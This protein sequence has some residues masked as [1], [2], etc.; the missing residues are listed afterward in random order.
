MS[1]YWMSMKKQAVHGRAVLQSMRNIQ[2]ATQLYIRQKT[3]EET[4]AA[5]IQTLQGLAHQALNTDPDRQVRLQILRWRLGQ[6]ISSLKR[7]VFVRSHQVLL[8]L[9]YAS[10]QD[11]LVHDILKS[12]PIQANSDVK[13]FM[14]C[15]GSARSRYEEM[16]RLPQRMNPEIT[17]LNAPKCF[18]VDWR[19]L[20]QLDKVLRFNFDP[21][22]VPGMGGLGRVRVQEMSAK[23]VGP[24]FANNPPV[25]RWELGPK[26]VDRTKDGRTVLYYMPPVSLLQ[27]KE[28]DQWIIDGAEYAF[29]LPS[30]FCEGKITCI[31]S[32][33]HH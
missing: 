15:T 25:L 26:L 10:N 16:S 32:D 28:K 24:A 6:E 29:S 18:D 1:E 12:H 2:E 30:L 3:A 9:I 22:N 27:V 7:G 8:A 31:G 14:D 33:E 19:S 23:F 20:L 5:R 21:N 11:F 4:R 13:L 17:P